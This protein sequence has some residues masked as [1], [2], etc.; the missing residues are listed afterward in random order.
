MKKMVNFRGDKCV[1]PAL[2]II[3]YTHV[4]KLHRSP[5][6]CI[7]MLSGKIRQSKKIDTGNFSSL[8]SIMT[9]PG[10]TNSSCPPSEEN[11]CI[12]YSF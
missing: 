9:S 12:Q 3:Q 10:G 4:L 11:Y 2:N 8:L 1:Y 5:S 7:F 6:M